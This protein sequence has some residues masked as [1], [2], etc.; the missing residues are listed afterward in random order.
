MAVI[1][2]QRPGDAAAAR[3][4]YDGKFIDGSKLT[5]FTSSIVQSTSFVFSRFLC[6]GRPIKIEIIIDSDTHVRPAP[7]PVPSL[8]GRIG[9]TAGSPKSGLPAPQSQAP[10]INVL[11]T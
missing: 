3:A 1:T 2:F 10:N 7:A 9:K 6:L 5:S 4:R 8:L 11:P